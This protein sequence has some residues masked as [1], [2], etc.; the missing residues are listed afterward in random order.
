M[1]RTA[2]FLIAAVLAVSPDASLACN[3]ACVTH[4]ALEHAGDVIV[5]TDCHDPMTA[6][7]WPVSALVREPGAIGVYVNPEMPGAVAPV[8]GGPRSPYESPPAVA[9]RPT[10]FHGVLRI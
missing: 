4:D 9:P 10:G 3:L 2:A 6:S 1:H 5:A 7:Q 8:Y